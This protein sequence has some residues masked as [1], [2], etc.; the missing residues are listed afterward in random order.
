MPLFTP[1]PTPKAGLVSSENG[2]AD[3]TVRLVL[4]RLALHHPH[5]LPPS[6]SDRSKFLEKT[7]EHPEIPEWIWYGLLH[8]A[9]ALEELGEGVDSVVE[10]ADFGILDELLDAEG[11]SEPRRLWD[12]LFYYMFLHLEGRAKPNQIT[13]PPQNQATVPPPQNQVTAPPPPT[14]K[15]DHIGET[16]LLERP[17]EDVYLLTFL[18]LMLL[19]SSCA[20]ILLLALPCS[21]LENLRCVVR[22]VM[23]AFS[24]LIDGSLRRHPVREAFRSTCAETAQ[25]SERLMDRYCGT[26]ECQTMTMLLLDNV[27]YRMGLL[28][29][30]GANFLANIRTEL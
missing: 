17:R 28:E 18:S 23:V 2:S 1:P 3:D 11:L 19:F 15:N 20:I 10:R 4:N 30:P 7:R 12:A 6:L 26:K 25:L 21:T 9:V 27:K 29:L 8:F 22:D 24:M 13:A 14:P 5:L 16:I